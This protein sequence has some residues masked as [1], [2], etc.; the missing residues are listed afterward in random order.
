MIEIR[1]IEREDFGKAIRFAIRGMHFDWYMDRPYQLY[2]YG[3]YFWYLELMRATQVLA[4]YDDGRFVGVMLAELHGGERQYKSIG[5]RV[6][7]SVFDWMQKLFFKG[8]AGLYEQTAMALQQQFEQKYAADGELIFLAADPE[9]QV[10]GIGTALLRE[11]EKRE[12]GKRVF[13]HTDDA[14][15]YQFY[16]HRGFERV[17]EQDIVMDIMGK[18]VPLKCLVYTK[19]LGDNSKI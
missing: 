16:E 3:R 2:L 1:P 15:T 10:K 7:V 19:V 8:G 18:K 17:C 13:L 14:C 5:N 11:L 6:Y 9:A 4:A 12:P